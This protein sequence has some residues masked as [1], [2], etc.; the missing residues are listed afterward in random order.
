MNLQGKKINAMGDSITEGWGLASKED[1]FQNVLGRML[2][3]A[4]WPSAS[5]RS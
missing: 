1:S 5:P 2:G 4:A 3:A